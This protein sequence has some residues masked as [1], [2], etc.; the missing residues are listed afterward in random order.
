[1]VDLDI[2]HMYSVVGWNYK[3]IWSKAGRSN[4]YNGRID[5]SRIGGWISGL[6]G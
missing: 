6:R 5:M 2:D 4:E 3:G 1:M